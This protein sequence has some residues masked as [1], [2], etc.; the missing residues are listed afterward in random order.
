M[1]ANITQARSRLVYIEE[2]IMRLWSI[3]GVTLVA[4]HVLGS[5][6]FWIAREPDKWSEQEIKRMVTDSPWAKE[7]GVHVRGGAIPGV[8][9]EPAPGGFDNSGRGRAGMESAPPAPQI[10]VRWDSAAPVYEACAKGGMERHL[11]SCSSKLLYLSGL[12]KKFD[13]L[14][15]EFYIVGMSNYPNTLRGENAP[16]HSEAANAALERMSGRIQQ[17]TFLKRKGKPPSRPSYI[18]ALPAGPALL[19]IV[20]FPRADALSVADKEVVFESTDGTI[21]VKATFNLRR[22]LYQKKLEL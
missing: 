18:V 5:E 19:L 13:E 22:M 11:F 1:I 9:T 12:G 16:Q 20:F 10:L 6:D 7:A 3:L 4:V 14:R 8:E 2:E 17:T 15:K 21:E